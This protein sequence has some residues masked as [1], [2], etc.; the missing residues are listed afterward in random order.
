ME[1]SLE[2][3]LKEQHRN[4]RHD[5][6][7]IINEFIQTIEGILIDKLPADVS[8]ELFDDI[9]PIYNQMINDIMNMKQRVPKDV[10]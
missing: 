2:I 10:V 4:T 7:D 3:K 9:N 1:K 5:T 6:I 8:Y